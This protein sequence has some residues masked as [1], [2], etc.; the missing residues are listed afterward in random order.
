MSMHLQVSLE[1]RGIGLPGTKITGGCESP[2]I[3]TGN[4][5]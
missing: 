2:G 3:G 5:I 1:A 4:R